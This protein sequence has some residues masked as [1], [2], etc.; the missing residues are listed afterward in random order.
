MKELGGYRILSTAP[1]PPICPDT[2]HHL[3]L[4]SLPSSQ[5]PTSLILTKRRKSVRTVQSVVQYDLIIISKQD[6][7]PPP[8]LTIH[9]VCDCIAASSVV[10]RVREAHSTLHHS[11]ASIRVVKELYVLYRISYQVP[12]S[13]THSHH[14]IR[15]GSQKGRFFGRFVATSCAQWMKNERYVSVCFMFLSSLPSPQQHFIRRAIIV[16]PANALVS[17]ICIRESK[18]K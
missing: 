12:I 3:L 7:A 15:A 4:T 5:F 16:C 2:R 11:T 13:L 14:T 6:N 18:R 1:S 17:R 8:P 10:S 9:R